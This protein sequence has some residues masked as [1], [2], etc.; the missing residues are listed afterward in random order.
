MLFAAAGFASCDKDD[1]GNN[2]GN[3]QEEP[4]EQTATVSYKFDG[5]ADFLTLFN[6][7]IQYTDAAGETVTEDVK[8]LP[9]EKSLASVKLPYTAS[10]ELI[11]TAAEDYEEKDLYEVGKGFAIYYQTSDG[12]VYGSMGSSTMTIAKD[13]VAAYQEKTLAS[14]NKT[15]VEIPVK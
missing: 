4:Q 14:E 9:W 6:V 7:Q 3:G 15:S 10:M 1:N 8:A 12:R 2:N 11:M 13:K 5:G